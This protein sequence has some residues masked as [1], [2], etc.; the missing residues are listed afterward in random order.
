MALDKRKAE[1][2]FFKVLM[3][4]STLVV[5]GTV[6]AILAVVIIRGASVI[7]LSMITEMPTGG[8]YLE[9]AGGGIL[10][11]IVGS[12]YLAFGGTALA[13]AISLPV[14]L[15]LQRDYVTRS[16]FASLIRSSLDILW[17]IPSIVYGAFMLTIMF[18]VGMRAS[19]MAGIIVLTF[20]E[21][22]IMIKAMD[23]AIS[24]VPSRLKEASYALG[25]TRLETSLKVVAR[26]ALPGLIV[27]VLLAFGRGIGDGASVLLVSG[28]SDAIPSSLGDP[29]A[30]LPL[31]VFF[32]A[33][34][35]F[36][37]AQAKAYAA[38]FMLIVIIL[39]V[40]VASR[41]LTRRFTKYVVR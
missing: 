31:A 34:L 19:L 15:F 33:G 27:A 25:A 10:N 12:L 6:L 7:S 17:G 2:S 18:A 36:P 40:S 37:G 1:E 23:T 13:A 4:A 39:I 29:V 38:A 16:R 8:Y 22:P 5:I 14:A 20:L 11:A 26:Q 41:L 28:Y 9:T 3:V 21:F 35:P 30:S 24:T 32:Q